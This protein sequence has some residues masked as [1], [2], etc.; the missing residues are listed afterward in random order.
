MVLRGMVDRSAVPALP[1]V[2][3]CGVDDLELLDEIDRLSRG[4][5]HGVDHTVMV[6]QYALRII[7][8]GDRLGYAY[9]YTAGGPYL[10]GATDT[11]TAALLMWASLAEAGD[12]PIDVD[13]L[14]SQHGW[15]IDVGLRARLQ[16]HNRATSPCGAC[17]PRR[18]TSRRATSCS[19][20]Q[21][22]AD[23]SL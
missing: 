7:R 10:L 17:H 2:R 6:D 18:R 22:V 13:H 4:A 1:G 3:E 8:N 5:G 19:R 21:P 20:Q 16:V 9:T 12:G 23:S 15:A 11:E 14:T